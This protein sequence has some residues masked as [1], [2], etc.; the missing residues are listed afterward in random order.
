MRKITSIKSALLMALF[1]VAGQAFAQTNLLTNGGFEDWTDGVPT[2]WKSASTASSAT[3]TQS[4]TAKS[5][6][7]SVQVGGATNANKRLATSEITLKAGTYT[8]AVSVTA[9][10]EDDGMFAL[11]Y[12]PVTDGKVGAYVYQTEGKSTLYTT[13]TEGE[14]AN[15]SYTFTLA[16][17][18]TLCLLVMNSKTAG[19][20]ILVDDASL[21]TD[22]GGTGEG[23]GDTPVDPD[24][25][26]PATAT[27]LNAPFSSGQDGFT[28]EDK[29]LPEGIETVWTFDS[30][31]GMKAT[32]FANSTSAASESW[33]ISPVVDLTG[34]T[35]AVLTFDH[36]ANFF[37]DVATECTAWIAE[38]GTGNWTQLP[39]TG[40]PT[41]WPFVSS[42]EIDLA[43]YVG[44]SIQVAFKYTSTDEKTGTW[45]IKNVLI[46]GEG[47][48]TVDPV[49][50]DTPDT[51][52]QG[53]EESPYTVADV[54]AL[55]NPDGAPKAWVKGYIVGYINGMSY[56]TGATFDANGEVMTN[57][58]LGP[59]ADATDPALCIPVALPAGSVRT[60]L[61]LVDH[62]KLLGQPVTLYGSLEKYFGVPGLKSVTQYV[63][64][65]GDTPEE[66]DTELRVYTQA[67]TVESGAKYLIAAPVEGA[68]KVALPLSGNYGYLQV[69]EVTPE[70]SGELAQKTA[71][72]EFELTAVDGGYTI[73]ASDGRYLYMTGTFNSFNVTAEPT[74][75][76]VWT[77]EPAAEGGFYITNTEK[78]KYIQY[79]TAYVS[80]GSYAD[81]QENAVLPRLFRYNRNVATGIEA[82]E[83]PT[84][85]A[86]VAVYTLGGQKVG[87]SLQG[88]P[89]GIYIVKQGAQARKVLK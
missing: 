72:N 11:G 49:E 81:D 53:T 31:Y 76:Y 24:P 36:A 2:G 58:I 71:A 62:P 52:G 19:K 74:E 42:G 6:A 45:E 4:E 83:A 43:A 10:T 37:A 75:G 14:W 48:T 30:R 34:A 20:D 70:A 9:A 7:Y 63:L 61:N 68:Y 60:E 69:E 33:L 89:K 64:E 82:V 54:L 39:V 86:P 67:T 17:E 77:I 25:E 27:Y 38:A 50:P 13:V 1:L 12:V 15:G 8:F 40:Y 65:G 87:S 22:D 51:E 66:P 85:D 46:K 57:L 59:A 16:E 47:G 84:T 80:Y 21:T 41:G 44:K 5:G 32:A 3:L 28:V 88:L 79:A 78:G 23:G 18:T 29:V 73:K 35:S 56:A 26:D 55:A